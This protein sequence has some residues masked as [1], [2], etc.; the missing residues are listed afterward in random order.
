MKEDGTRQEKSELLSLTQKYRFMREEE[1][2]FYIRKS[3]EEVQNTCQ[4]VLLT[5][6]P[7]NVQKITKTFGLYK[8]FPTL[9]D[10][11]TPIKDVSIV[12]RGFLLVSHLMKRNEKRIHIMNSCLL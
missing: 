8:E 3:M 1:L 10:E 7:T 9:V 11:N 2:F 6:L 4:K 5:E 12:V